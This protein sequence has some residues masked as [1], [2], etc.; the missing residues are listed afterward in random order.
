MKRLIT[1]A[2]LLL[3]IAFP[4][5]AQDNQGT[6]L[7]LLNLR[8]DPVVN[9]NILTQLPIDTPV[10]I[11][12]RNP[13]GSWLWIN[14]DGVTGWVSSRYIGWDGI[15]LSNI[16]IVNTTATHTSIETPI[17]APTVDSNSSATTQVRLNLRS[18]PGTFGNV[19]DILAVN[20]ALILLGRNADG[21]WLAVDVGGVQGWVSSAYVAYNGDISAL[22]VIRDITTT[23]ITPVIDQS[24]ETQAPVITDGRFVFTGPDP[25]NST[26]YDVEITLHWN[27]TAN[28]DLRVT[29]PDGYTI[30]PGV[31]PSPT[32][33]YFQQGIGANEDCTSAEAAPL[34]VVTWQKGTAPSGLYRIEA[35]HVNSCFPEQ[36]EE[37]LFWVSV[38]NDGPEVEFWVFF[39]EPDELF[40]FEFVRP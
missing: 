6:T 36:E 5:S 30:I 32:G 3:L 22:P 4:A 2:I 13:T 1:L 28:L 15:A 35:D 18:E 39:I 19:L 24:N 11:L 31:P 37:T 26:S 21:A 7:D 38:K 34:E 16:P 40:E 8:A 20:Q 14:A 23:T 9:D 12:G 29:G 33:G 27:T 10:T 17:Q 25:N